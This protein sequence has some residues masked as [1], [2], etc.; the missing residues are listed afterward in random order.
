VLVAGDPL[1]DITVLQDQ[2]RLTVIKSG[3]ASP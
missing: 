2:S 3:V 1:E